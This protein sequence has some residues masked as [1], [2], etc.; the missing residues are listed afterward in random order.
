VIRC[1]AKPALRPARSIVRLVLS[2]GGMLALAA[3]Q[4]SRPLDLPRGAAAYAIVP[5]ATAP[6]A[7]AARIIRPGDTIAVQVFREPELSAPKLVVDE[8][9]YVP[10]PL[11]GQVHAAGQT[12][13]QL[14]EVIAGQLGQRY[15]R[16]PQV[17]V[18]V[19][20]VLPVTVA[21]EGQ[22]RTPGVF[23]VGAN[24]TLLTAVARAGSPA[25]E[26]KLNEV[27]VFRTVE[28]RRMGAVFDL[29]DIRA[30]RAPDP[31]LVDGDRVVVGF[32]QV[33]GG[34]RQFLQVAP[35]IGLFTLF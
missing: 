29:A 18:A 17:T 24:E 16:H 27:V 3:C 10:L 12:P 2:L 11:L 6:A 1:K 26:A 14:R 9:G 19:T 25:A 23:A 8:L 4:S 22:V 15:L 20:D 13:A 34:L 35:L 32:S 7:P 5:A 33:Q 31:P 28:G 30:G 21:V